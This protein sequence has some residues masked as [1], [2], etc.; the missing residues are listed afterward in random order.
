VQAGDE[1]QQGN[2]VRVLAR[3]APAGLADDLRRVLRD[4]AR[5]DFVIRQ[6]AMA[7][8]DLGLVELID[9][10]AFAML[11]SPDSA[12]HQDGSIAL[13]LLTPDD[14]LLDVATRLV[15]C[16]DGNLFAAL[17]KERM[18]AAER[19]ELARALAV[20]RVDVLSDDR[21]D[22]AVAAG[23][24][25]PDAGV[26]RAAACAATFWRDDSEEVKALLDLDPQ[27]AALGLLEARDHGA[28]WWDVAGHA[29]LDVL[30]G[31]AVDQR[32][33][34]A[35]ELALE[36][37]AMSAAER[38]ELR[39]T[40]EAGRARDG[41]AGSPSALAHR[42]SPSCCGG[43]QRLRPT[44]RCKPTRSTCGARS[45]RSRTRTTRAPGTAGGVVAGGPVQGLGDRRRRAVFADRPRGRVAV[46]CTGRRDAG[47]R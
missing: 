2:A 6:A 12:V 5:Y 31:A 9:D 8:A 16:R 29:D 13:R 4:P 40:A 25:T 23:E 1:I 20:A 47:D 26:V 27:A 45:A 18:S 3:V 24:V 43:G 37:R 15:P 7:A 30:R 17:V 42:S 39:R 36:V 22:L 21:A 34:E 11:E 33:I 35:A 41:E 46:S 32:V 19:I 44:R 10:V 38:D 28:E 14:R